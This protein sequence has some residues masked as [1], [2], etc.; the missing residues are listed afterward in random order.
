LA[1]KGTIFIE[2]KSSASKF[3]GDFFV[4]MNELAKMHE[5]KNDDEHYVLLFV[6]GCRSNAPQVAGYFVWSQNESKVHL[7]PVNYRGNVT[8]AP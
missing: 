1:G 7:S 8:L 6:E 5:A 4:S 2:V 3:T